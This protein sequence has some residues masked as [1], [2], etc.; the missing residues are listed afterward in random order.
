MGSTSFIT[1]GYGRTAEEAFC[2]SSEQALWEWGHNGY[3][4]TIA[5]KYDFV[6]AP[7]PSGATA[8]E[9][10]DTLDARDEERLLGWYSKQDVRRYVEAYEDKRG[11][12]VVV[13][14]S[15]EEA[16]THRKSFG[17]DDTQKI[18]VFGGHASC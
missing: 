11:P 12:A 7:L 5:E 1:V 14:A 4:G 3:T 8:R 18:W 13:Q 2:R 15:D 10:I 9:V 6:L 17:V 16:E